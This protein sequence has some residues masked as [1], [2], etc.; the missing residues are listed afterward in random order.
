MTIALGLVRI[1]LGVVMVWAGVAKAV[2]PSSFQHAISAFDLVSVP[3]S[4]VGA[5]YLPW[6][7]IVLGVALLMGS[8]GWQSALLLTGGVVTLFTV[9]MASAVWRGLNPDCGCFGTGSSTAAWGVARNVGLI[10]MVL[11]LWYAHVRRGIPI[12]TLSI[13]RSTW[14]LRP[15]GIMVGVMVVLAGVIAIRGVAPV[16]SG[17]TDV[18]STTQA[19][20][21]RVHGATLPAVPTAARA[22]GV[23]QVAETPAPPET[24]SA[25]A[26]DG[27]SPEHRHDVLSDWLGQLS[28]GDAERSLLM[29]VVSDRAYDELTRNRAVDVLVAQDRPAEGLA[30]MLMHQAEDPDES[31]KWRDYAVQQVAQVSRRAIDIETAVRFLYRMAEDRRSV[32][33]GTAQLALVQLSMASRITLD[34]TFDDAVLALAMDAE[35]V[36][37]AHITALM[38]AGER[39]LR[40]IL[41]LARTWTGPDQTVAI[42]RA[43]LRAV[44]F[45][46]DASDDGLF[47]DAMASDHPL[48]AAAARTGYE[49]LLARLR[50]AARPVSPLPSTK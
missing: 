34:R 40:G 35:A 24:T 33:A 44:G 10:G 12:I 41:P 23:P 45:L 49:D 1:L 29:R 28:L 8:W 47:Q 32:Y 42:R 43:A 2:D 3:V 37:A 19:P 13:R 14:E 5:L 20:H 26:W 25:R 38:L 46:G 36:D 39:R 31:V 17:H 11:L 22:S 18:G 27:W 9:V 16:D 48:V 21:V 7:E 15:A 6:L 50:L 30:V 4:A